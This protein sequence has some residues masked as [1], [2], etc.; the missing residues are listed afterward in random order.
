MPR[1]GAAVAAGAPVQGGADSTREDVIMAN[2]DVQ[3]RRGRIWSWLI[4]VAVLALLLW[5]L[6]ELFGG[7]D[8]G[9]E[10]WRT[11]VAAPA[12]SVG[13]ATRAA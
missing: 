7:D 12:A 8:D 3:K 4:G 1:R 13:T 6:A 5:L 9:R 11:G 2:L 10:P